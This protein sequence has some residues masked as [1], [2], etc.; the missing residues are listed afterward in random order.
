MSKRITRLDESATV[1]LPPEAVDA[2]GV[3]PGAE[4][5]IEIVGRA[6]VVRSSEEAQRSGE[7]AKTFEMVLTRRRKAYERL[8]EGPD[9]SGH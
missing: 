4:L 2:L 3:K 8:A 6:I 5:D 9:R 1:V 7:F